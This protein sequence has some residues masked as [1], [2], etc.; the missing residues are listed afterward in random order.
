MGNIVEI[1]QASKS[2]EA[3]SESQYQD[4]AMYRKLGVLETVVLQGKDDEDCEQQWL[5][6]LKGKDNEII[7]CSEPGMDRLEQQ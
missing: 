3:M 5:E 4:L 6:Y 2:T 7:Y 1:D